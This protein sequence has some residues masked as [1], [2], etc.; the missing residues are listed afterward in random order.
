MAAI[1]ALTMTGATALAEPSVSENVLYTDVG[2]ITDNQYTNQTLKSIVA[3]L[4]DDYTAEAPD[5]FGDI[6][7]MA[8]GANIATSYPVTIPVDHKAF[9][10]IIFGGLDGKN[11]KSVVTLHHSPVTAWESDETNHW[12]VCNMYGC[13]EHT[14]GTPAP[15]IPTVADGDC[16]AATICGTCER[17]LSAGAG[18]HI[19]TDIFDSS[20]D[21]P[22]CT[23]SARPTSAVN[24]TFN[25]N[26]GSAIN[27]SVIATRTNGKLATIPTP[28][29]NG[30][31]FDGWYT[32]QTGGFKIEANSTVFYGNATVYA[33]WTSQYGG[34]GS[35][36]GGGSGGGGS[37][38]GNQIGNSVCSI[39]FETNGGTSINT[40]TSAKGMTINFNDLKTTRKGYEFA[41]WYSDAALTKEVS[42]VVLSDNMKVYAKWVETIDAPSQGEEPSNGAF[43]DVSESD[44]FSDAVNYVLEN[45]LMNGVSETEFAP[46]NTT[47][48]A[49]LVTM[50]Y[51]LDGEP[52]I[53]ANNEFLDV[54]E[55]SYYE[56]AVIWASNNEIAGGYGDGVFGSGNPITRE[57]LASILYRYASYKGYD[58]SYED[59][60][61]LS[62][63][64]A[65]EISEYAYPA[66]QWA[67]KN[68]IINGDGNKLMPLGSAERCQVATML[69]RFCEMIKK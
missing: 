18:S 40:Y 20:C 68:G 38:G 29:R 43:S 8:D 35:F 63:D 52:E 14:A 39:T 57:Q 56:N 51:R 58:T 4:S 3:F 60:N 11:V 47:T 24:V 61:I 45:G 36:T 26:G 27:P 66:L 28:V 19:Y 32:A 50:L 49:M 59:T 9:V 33:H 31:K 10:I 46:H 67:C 62:F 37:I 16:T 64:D 41:G 6:I 48:R 15:H 30:W 17:Q 5:S 44:W 23:F 65:F 54:A 25:S 13:T 42:T 1:L 55:N 69:M 53:T 22:G 12:E 21:T 34:T 7:L 2:S